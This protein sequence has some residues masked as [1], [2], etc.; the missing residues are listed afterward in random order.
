[1]KKCAAALVAAIAL[2]LASNNANS[3]TKIGYI[4]SQEM[5]TSMP[6]YK[7]ADSSL[8]DFQDALNQE[9]A[10]MVQDFNK[11]DSLLQSRDTVKLS[12]AKIELMR[13]EQQDLYQRLQGWQEQAKQL[14]QQKQDEL[15]GPIYNKVRAAISAV[16]KENGYAYVFVKEQLLAF[17]VGDDIEP[18]VKKKL[19]LK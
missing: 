18:L 2:L 7:K 12:K 19:G 11:K 1:M 5:I 4:S 17:P 14:Y 13:I 15:M 16:A 8:A 10:G 9:Y 6:E 3:Q